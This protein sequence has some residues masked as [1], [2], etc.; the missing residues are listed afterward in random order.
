MPHRKLTTPAEYLG[1]AL[2]TLQDSYSPA[3]TL[4][5]GADPAHL[6]IRDIFIYDDYNKDVQ[7]HHELD[8]DYKKDRELIK[9]AKG[10]VTA[11]A[12]LIKLVIREAVHGFSTSRFDKHF[13]E[14]IVKKFL[15]LELSAAVKRPDW[16]R[17]LERARAAH[18]KAQEL[19]RQWEQREQ[20]RLAAEQKRLEQYG[21]GMY[22]DSTPSP[23]VLQAK[24]DAEIAERVAREAIAQANRDPLRYAEEVTQA[25]LDAL[26]KARRLDEQKKGGEHP[27]AGYPP[28]PRA[29]D[30]GHPEYGS[31]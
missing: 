18:A 21:G 14:L 11:S 23:E 1:R 5:E 19:L 20:A 2:H 6:V 15:R 28:E 4:R 10:A 13:D 31:R 16:A 25:A 17:D 9:E 3:H 24:K 22:H 29:P 7:H 30:A 26:A 27:E 8:V 12:E